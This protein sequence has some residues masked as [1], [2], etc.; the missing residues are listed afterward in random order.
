MKHCGHPKPVARRPFRASCFG[1][2]YLIVVG[3]RRA[4]ALHV[5]AGAGPRRRYL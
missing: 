5:P 2:V 3:P 4:R 1:A